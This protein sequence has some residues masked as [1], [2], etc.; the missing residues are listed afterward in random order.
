MKK[1]GIAAGI[2]GAVVFVFSLSGPGR[3]D[4]GAVPP[5]ARLVR[6]VRQRLRPHRVP[7]V[8]GMRAAIS[9][10]PSRRTGPR[11]WTR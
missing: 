11:T 5:R 10:L 9:I 6:P 4:A 1:L 8:R 3:A 7:P 2:F